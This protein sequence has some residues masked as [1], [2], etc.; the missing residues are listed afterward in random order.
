MKRYTLDELP[1]SNKTTA[2]FCK[3]RFEQVGLQLK[4]Y[5]QWFE[6]ENGKDFWLFNNSI[7][8]TGLCFRTETQELD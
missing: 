1:I 2:L 3:K 6:S 8:Y 5:K 4:E 7:G